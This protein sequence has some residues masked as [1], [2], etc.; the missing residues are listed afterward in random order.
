MEQEGEVDGD[1]MDMGEKKKSTKEE[2]EVSSTDEVDKDKDKAEDDD[3]SDDDSEEGEGDDEVEDGELSDSESSPDDD[4]D[5]QDDAAYDRPRGSS[6][7]RKRDA[8]GSDEGKSLIDEENLKLLQE[9]EPFKKKVMVKQL[10]PELEDKF[11]PADVERLIEKQ[12]TETLDGLKYDPEEMPKLTKTIADSIQNKIR[13]LR[14]KRYK[15]LTYVSLGEKRGE[16]VSAVTRSIWD[17][18]TDCMA[19]FTYQSPTL[20][21]CATVYGVYFY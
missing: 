9:V 10:W 5:Y 7:W 12:V 18:L 1:M 4:V 11:R 8:G 20:Y 15:I 14:Y 13:S 19:T 2:M 16:G 6:I 17:P 3:D 21:C